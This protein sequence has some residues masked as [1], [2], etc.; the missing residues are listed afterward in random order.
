MLALLLLCVGLVR[1][2]I[3][4]LKSGDFGF[5]NPRKLYEPFFFLVFLGVLYEGR[6]GLL[7][8]TD[9]LE[10][11]DEWTAEAER[12]FEEDEA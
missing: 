11:L 10:S 8:L 9:G 12:C 1:L 6:G 4:D 3:L 5:S 7:E 2:G